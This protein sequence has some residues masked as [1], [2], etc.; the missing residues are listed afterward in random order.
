[1][2]GGGMNQTLGSPLGGMGGGGMNQTLGSPL[3]GMGGMNQTFG[4]PLGSMGGNL[5]PLQSLFGGANLQNQEVNRT[6]GSEQQMNQNPAPAV[7][8]QQNL[9]SDFLE[10][11]KSSISEV[12]QIP[13]DAQQQQEKPNF[14]EQP[15]EKD[16]SKEDSSKSFENV[17]KQTDSLGSALEGLGE[18]IK[19]LTESMKDGKENNKDKNE[20]Q[21]KG[22]SSNE[23]KELK[24][25]DVNANVSIQSSPD[26]ETQ[27]KIAAINAII[28]DFQSQ[29]NTLKQQASGKV[30]PPQKM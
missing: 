14:Q 25:S 24:I 5:N 12:K 15:K 9:V 22:A 11:L 26:T 3:G 19:S 16:Q 30:N 27:A 28:K 1:M 7:E 13:Q 20:S 10:G 17:I 23:T 4:S 2:G 29:L 8:N 18:K 6:A 21:E